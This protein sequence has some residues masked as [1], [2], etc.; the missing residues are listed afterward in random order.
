MGA[1]KGQAKR[2]QA[3]VTA[4]S[5]EQRWVAPWSDFLINQ[6]L[7]DT[8]LGDYYAVHMADFPAGDGQK[9]AFQQKLAQEIFDD[10]VATGT[11]CFGKY[12]ALG[13]E[14]LPKLK[15][16]VNELKRDQYQTV[17]SLYI[18]SPRQVENNRAL[19]FNYSGTYLRER[20][21]LGGEEM[22]QVIAS[23][24]NAVVALVFRTV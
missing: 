23:L 4:Y 13:D 8:T 16:V 18:E 5:Q 11:L 12:H 17:E 21:K 22:Q 1:G 14:E 7:Q 3:S 9:C 24:H 19:I 15:C 20:A 2:V 6:G 10:L